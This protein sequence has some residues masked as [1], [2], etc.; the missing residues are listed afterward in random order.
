LPILRHFPLTQA[1]HVTAD[2]LHVDDPDYGRNVSFHRLPADERRFA[3]A[4][5]RSGGTDTAWRK[6]AGDLP[7]A[8]CTGN[9]LPVLLAASM[10][11]PMA[12]DELAIAKPGL[13][14]LAACKTVPLHV[15]ADCELVLEAG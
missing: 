13:T 15:P 4:S 6:A 5:S 3:A 8:I 1:L 12:R 9:S 2:S 11:P 10:S 7:V 14:P